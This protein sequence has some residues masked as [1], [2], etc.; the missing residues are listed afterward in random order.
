M[1]VDPNADT[2]DFPVQSGGTAPA[3]PFSSLVR[4]EAAAL[5]DRGKVR[6]ANEDHY[7]VARLGRYLDVLL[8]SLPEGEAPGRAEETGYGFVVADGIGG[9][10]GGELASRLAISTLV[11]LVLQVPDWILRMDDIRA[12]ESMKRVTRHY[13]KIDA[14]I[15]RRAREDRTLSGMGTTMTLAYSLG[16][17]LFVVQVGDSRAYLH[18]KGELQRL[19]RDHTLVQTLLDLGQI[20]PA[21][22]ASHPLRHILTQALGGHGQDLKAEVQ[23]LQLADGDCLLL[24][25]DGLTEMVTDDLIA[26]VLQRKGGAEEDCRTL[27]ELALQHGGR[28]NV[29]VIVARYRFP[30]PVTS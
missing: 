20:T 1:S 14:E 23:R 10:E 21:G 11:N 12:Q 5:S 27:V 6:A 26:S 17:D 8:T 28:D 30:D 16:A 19:T 9:A 24:C 4:V 22:A 25:T 13:R 7:L 2:G 18:R 29:T 15:A 3:R